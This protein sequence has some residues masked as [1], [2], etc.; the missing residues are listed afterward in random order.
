MQGVCSRFLAQVTAARQYHSGIDVGTEIDI[1]EHDNRRPSVHGLAQDDP[2]GFEFLHWDCDYFSSPLSEYLLVFLNSRIESNMT[3][4]RIREFQSKPKWKK[5]AAALFSH[6]QKNALTIPNQIR[7]FKPTHSLGTNDAFFSWKEQER[8][9]SEGQI[10]MIVSHPYHSIIY[11][12]RIRDEM[13]QSNKFLHCFFIVIVV[14]KE[15]SHFD[16]VN[17][18]FTI[19]GEGHSGQSRTEG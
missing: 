6:G 10:K 18:I 3:P 5:G 14:S 1:H 8:M 16:L 7:R 9:C 13:V 17:E 2:A 15:D 4:I 19:R 11:K 12:P